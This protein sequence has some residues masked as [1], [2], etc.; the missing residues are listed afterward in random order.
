MMGATSI[1][2]IVA[3]I[4]SVVLSIVAYAAIVFAGDVNAR[5]NAILVRKKK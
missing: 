5:M 1:V 3:V 2:L 4:L